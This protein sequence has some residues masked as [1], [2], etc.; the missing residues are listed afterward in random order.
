MRFLLLAPLLAVLPT[1]AL[2]DPLTFGEALRRATAEAPSLRA[3]SLEVDARRST[4]VSAGRLPDPR[5]GVGLDNFP[6]SG[7]PAWSFDRDE[8]TMARLGISQ[9]VPNGA[10]RR[11]RTGRAEADIGVAEA[12]RVAET[13]RVQV[14]T[15]LAWI[16]LAYA[17]RRLAAIGKALAELADYVSPAASSVASGSARPAQTLEIRQ[18]IAVLEDRRSEVASEVARARAILSRWTGDPR[19]EIEGALPD[20][21]ID[22]DQLRTAIAQHPDLD[23]AI[24][25]V[26]AAE[27]DVTLAR[28]DKRPDWGLDLAYQRRGSGYGDMV[29]AGVTVSL[30]L[31][32]KRRQDPMIASS[33]A[34]EGAAL[35]QREDLRRALIADLEAGLADHVMHHEQWM[36]AQDTLLPLARQRVDL[37]T[38][39]YSAGRA[40]LLDLI[41]AQT[42]FADAALQALDREATVARDAARL[43]LTYGGDQ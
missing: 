37:E 36:R 40:T 8:M 18:A 15:A 31:F 14:A 6:I 38:V 29:S 25:R 17:E 33:I 23:A 1:P 3:R 22:P 41:Q 32:A 28:A 13:R 7:P 35:A 21:A 20:F 27:A 42:M 4:A 43:V 39:S 12:D 16:D 19:P 24:A 30:P 2:A 5:L 34:S 11:A 10:K 26:R 9:E